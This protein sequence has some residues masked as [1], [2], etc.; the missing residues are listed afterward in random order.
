MP[1]QVYFPVHDD[2]HVAEKASVLTGTDYPRWQTQ[3][4]QFATI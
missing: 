1:R 3:V 2:E 4:V